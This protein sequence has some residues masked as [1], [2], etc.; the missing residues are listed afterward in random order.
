MLPLGS[1]QE[2]T[3]CWSVKMVNSTKPLAVVSLPCDSNQRSTCFFW[4]R[5][6]TNLRAL[7]ICRGPRSEARKGLC[8]IPTSLDSNIQERLFYV[9]ILK[10]IG[11]HHEPEKPCSPLRAS[12][13][14]LASFA[15]K[16]NFVME[17]EHFEQDS[18]IRTVI[19][20]RFYL[21]N[22]VLGLAA[23]DQAKPFGIVL[24]V[25]FNVIRFFY[26]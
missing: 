23:V 6:A 22:L 5:N 7:V 19:M 8:H 10:G 11:A 12:L 3:L 16:L 17:V 18:D 2:I 25:F 9:K 1:G 26:K 14:Q 24:T 13:F 4:C 20:S 21:Y 15:S